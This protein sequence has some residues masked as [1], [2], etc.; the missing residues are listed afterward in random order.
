MKPRIIGWISRDSM[1]PAEAAEAAIAKAREVCGT[2]VGVLH[3]DTV[4]GRLSLF[5]DVDAPI[6]A[7]TFVRGVRYN[8]DPDVLAADLRSEALAARLITGKQPKAK[9]PKPAKRPGPAPGSRYK[10]TPDEEA[11]RKEAVGKLIRAEQPVDDICAAYK[12]TRSTLYRWR[13]A[14]AD[15]DTEAA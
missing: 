6:P 2:E 9:K 11:R 4:T 14:F 1:S 7:A 13:N 12:C 15:R 10:M 3:M 8:S 5:A